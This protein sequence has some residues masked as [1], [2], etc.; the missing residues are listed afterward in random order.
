VVFDLRA[1]YRLDPHVL[2]A[3]VFENVGDTAYRYHGSSVNGPGR[4]AILEV[5]FGF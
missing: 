1:G 4:G 2:L 5:Q 3:L